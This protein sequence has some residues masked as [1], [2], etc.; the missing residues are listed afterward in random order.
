MASGSKKLPRLSN[1]DGVK[2]LLKQGAATNRIDDQLRAVSKLGSNV[3]KAKS[4][5]A[6][7]NMSQLAYL[8]V[9]APS[10][11]QSSTDPCLDFD[12]SEEH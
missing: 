4:P 10:N 7:I 11:S 8:L 1:A 6:Q 12:Q 3:D 5:K 9:E 2:G